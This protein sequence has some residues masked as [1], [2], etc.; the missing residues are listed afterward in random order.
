MLGRRSWPRLTKRASR[1]ARKASGLMH[2]GGGGNPRRSFFV[3]RWLARIV[4]FQQQPRQSLRPN[5][6]P[7]QASQ[8]SYR[9]IT[10][11]RIEILRHGGIIQRRAGRLP[12]EQPVD[13]S[14]PHPQFLQ[15]W[16][17]VA[18]QNARYLMATL[19]CDLSCKRI[20]VQ[21][22]EGGQL[23]NDLPRSGGDP[24]QCDHHESSELMH[25]NKK[26]NRFLSSQAS[27]RERS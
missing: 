23:M 26:P 2:Q 7:R 21:P 18:G 27:Q 25:S 4:E 5:F 20:R 6:T 15:A 24:M 1:S 10:T 8:S 19:L 13:Q 12:A 14:N 16:Q 17:S 22:R 3:R 11:S 9:S